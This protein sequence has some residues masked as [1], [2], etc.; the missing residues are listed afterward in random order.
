[1]TENKLR[2]TIITIIGALLLIAGLLAVKFL[3]I[4]STAIP[5]ICIGIGCGLFG[6]GVGELI[7]RRS[8]KNHPEIARQREIEKNDERN[9]AIRDRAQAKAYRIMMPLFGALFV[10]FGLMN[11]EIKFILILIA[12]YLYVCG[13]SIYYSEKYRKEM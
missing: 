8:E 1:M 4:G 9:V 6:Q 3:D 5:Y 12:A 7:T 11:M 13:C 2:N 10:A